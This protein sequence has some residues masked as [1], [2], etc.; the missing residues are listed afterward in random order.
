MNSD[1]LGNI[2][3]GIMFAVIGLV[4][5]V[6]AFTMILIRVIRMDRKEID[7]VSRLPL[8]VHAAAANGDTK[9]E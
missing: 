8:D 3:S 2:G 1:S 4:V 7:T 5:F 6:A 9:D